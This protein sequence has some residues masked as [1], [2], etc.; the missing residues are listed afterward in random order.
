MKEV[1]FR[2]KEL[3]RWDAAFPGT[4]TVRLPSVGHGVQQPAPD[5]VARAAGALLRGAPVAAAAP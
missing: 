2:E 4:R 5:G 3:R 1:G